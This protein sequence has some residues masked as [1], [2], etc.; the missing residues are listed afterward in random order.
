MNLENIEEIKKEILEKLEK[1][2]DAK[3]FLDIRLEYLGKKGKIRELFEKIKDLSVEEK[4]VFGDKLNKLKGDVEEDFKKFEDSF[5]KEKKDGFSDFY[6]SLPGKKPEAGHINVISQAIS[7]I[8][9]VFTPLGFTRVRY[10]E[11]DWEY[12]AFEALNMP[13]SHPAR[14]E[15]ETFFVDY[16]ADSKL[17]KLVITPHTSNGQIHEMLK[18]DLPIRMLNISRCGRRQIDISHVP[19]FYQ[20]EGLVI[21]K[22]ISVSNLKGVL[23]YFARNFF[24]GERKTRLRPYDFRFTEPS[25]EVDIDCG[26][27]HGKGCK[28]CKGGWLELGGAGMVH[29]NVLKA[30][31]ISDS[32]YGGFAFGWGVERTYMMKSGTKIDDIRYL[33]SNDM[34]FLE[35]F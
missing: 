1:A 6:K 8:V 18:G 3:E 15:W 9:S 14:D 25:F 10:P 17:G 31:G 30:G 11:I 4:K 35:Q 13:K 24:G 23:N 2:K 20:F 16:P 26:I 29:P 28:L 27:C 21:D 7:E 5:G 19:S 33:F 22:N 34:R 32:E 12:Y